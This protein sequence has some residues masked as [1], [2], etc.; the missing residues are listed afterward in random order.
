MPSALKKV[1]A[2]TLFCLAVTACSPAET[3]ANNTPKADKAATATGET[4]TVS[5]SGAAS[6]GACPAVLQHQMPSIDNQSRNLCDYADRVVLVV[7]TASFC[8]YTPQYEQLEALYQKYKA[9][10][11]VVLGFPANQFG[12][13]EPGSN[14]EIKAFCEDKYKVSF[15]LFAKSAVRG[16]AP[17]PLYKDLIQMTGK[18]PLWNF[19]KYL[20]DK[21]GKVTSFKS[22]VRPNSPV[23]IK[24]IE[25]AL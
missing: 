2:G 21:K 1:L 19:H 15:P 24:E 9:R 7:N 22:A 14:T 3:E 11:F 10:G 12:E 8:G 16:P 18:E 13:Q 5:Y 25:T 20:I 23:L 17:N 6:T 4:R